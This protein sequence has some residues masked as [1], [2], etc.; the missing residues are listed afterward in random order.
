VIQR[1]TENL[2]VDYGKPHLSWSLKDVFPGNQRR[3]PIRPAASVTQFAQCLLT[4][5][6]L[7]V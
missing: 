1:P 5:G 6:D 3:N 2:A 7:N 4:G